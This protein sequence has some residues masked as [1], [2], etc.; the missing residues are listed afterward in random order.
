[1]LQKRFLLKEC[2]SLKGLKGEL[3]MQAFLEVGENERRVRESDGKYFYTEKQGTGL[4]RSMQ[5]KQISCSDYLIKM[6]KRVGD[7]ITKVRYHIPVKNGFVVKVDVY[8]GA[9]AGLVLAEVD[10]DDYYALTRFIRPDWIGEDVTKDRRYMNANLALYG[11]PK[12]DQS[13]M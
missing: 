7:I 11:L 1:M 12:E 10:F 2:P 3:I 4:E 8:K 5:T 9:H 13:E 6:S